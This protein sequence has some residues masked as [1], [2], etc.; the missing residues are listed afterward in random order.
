MTGHERRVFFYVCSLHQLLSFLTCKMHRG[1]FMSRP[2]PASAIAVIAWPAHWLRRNSVW[3]NQCKKDMDT[4][5]QK[6]R[7]HTSKS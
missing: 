2:K 7:L 3:K 6:R 1:F 5:S 4:V